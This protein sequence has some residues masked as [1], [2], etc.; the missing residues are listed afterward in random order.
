MFNFFL[1]SCKEKKKVYEPKVIVLLYCYTCQGANIHNFPL[2]M[3]LKCQISVIMTWLQ[4][5]DRKNHNA[6]R[7]LH[8]FP[9]SE[10]SRGV[11]WFVFVFVFPT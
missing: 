8:T 1:E 10:D 5:K 3:K 6:G 2:G 9:P 7:S 11:S 4:S